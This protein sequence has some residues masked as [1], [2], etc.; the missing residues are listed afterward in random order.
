MVG[1]L[2]VDHQ[3]YADHPIPAQAIISLRTEDNKAIVVSIKETDTQVVELVHNRP[4]TVGIPRT[5]VVQSILA[6]IKAM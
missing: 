5:T 4:R 3:Q 6:N 2:V 1:V